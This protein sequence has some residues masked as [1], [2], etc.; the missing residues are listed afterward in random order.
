MLKIW[1]AFVAL[2]FFL[3]AAHSRQLYFQN[4]SAVNKFNKLSSTSY[5][6]NLNLTIG[7]IN[8]L[9]QFKKSS[10]TYLKKEQSTLCLLQLTTGKKDT[11]YYPAYYP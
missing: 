4:E 11:I 8:N 9:E 5:S 10:C 1:F 7:Q 3:I 6:V 2:S